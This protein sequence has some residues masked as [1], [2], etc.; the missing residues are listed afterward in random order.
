MFFKLFLTALFGVYIGVIILLLVRR[1][2]PKW[3]RKGTSRPPVEVENAAGRVFIELE[4]VDKSFDEQSVL[5]QTNLKIFQGETLG[6]LGKSGS[7]KSVLLKLIVGLLEP[8]EGRILFKGEDITMM[9]EPQLLEVRKRVSYVFQSGA[10]FDSLD[11]KENVAYPLR[12]Q[13]ILDEEAIDRRVTELLAD[14]ELE[15]MGDQLFDELSAGS[16]KQVAI[17]RAIANA[18]EAILYD[19]PTTGVDPIIGKSLNRLIRKLNKQNNLTSVVVTH[20]LR[21][22]E[23]VA[24]RIILIKDG[25]IHFEGGL[26]E[27]HASQAPYVRAFIAGSHYEEESLA[28]A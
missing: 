12:E 15:G 2:F 18:P 1:F 17:A 25:L 21:C 13:G 20:D 6:V 27:F 5:K 22:I 14:V 23:M 8:D 19:E 24:D 26:D 11:V 10:F 28:T 3:S 4:Q 9:E 7:G 16:K